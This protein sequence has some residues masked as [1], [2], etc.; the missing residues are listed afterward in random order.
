ILSQ[1]RDSLMTF[2]AVNRR[3]P[4]RAL[5]LAA[6]FRLLR[7]AARFSGAL[8]GRASALRGA[9]RIVAV[10]PG[11][12]LRP[13]LPAG[14]PAAVR[15]AFD[16]S[17]TSPPPLPFDRVSRFIV[18]FIRGLFPP[19]TAPPKK[20]KTPPGSMSQDSDLCWTALRPWSGCRRLGR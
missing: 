16:R 13:P 7:A 15:R 4:R 17:T 6:A 2:S 14:L 1:R 19:G 18:F 20:T 3:V 12:P 9:T 10:G 11:P 5:A 8:T